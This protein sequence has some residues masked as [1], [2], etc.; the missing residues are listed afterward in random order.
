[1]FVAAALAPLAVRPWLAASLW[2]W[3]VAIALAVTASVAVS[4]YFWRRGADAMPLAPIA[5]ACV[6]GVLIAYGEL[7]PAENAVRSHHALANELNRIVPAQVGTLN[8]F[9]EIDEGLWFYLEAST[10]RPCRAQ[11]PAITRH[12]T[13]PTAFSRSAKRTSLTRAPRSQTPGAR[14]TG[15]HR[16]GRPQSAEHLV[17]ADPWESL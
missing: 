6:V 2:L 9:N 3:S 16:L 7:A 4:V 1:M 14:Q 8:F 5:T 15:S 13:L 10:F 11:I 12:T 17:L